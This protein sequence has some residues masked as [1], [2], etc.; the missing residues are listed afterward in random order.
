MTDFYT[1]L[2]CK[3]NGGPFYVG[4]GH[5]RRS[6]ML[7]QRS[8]YH[9]RMIKK[10]GVEIFVFPCE[11]EEQAFADEIQQIAQLRAEGYKL[12][13]RTD[14]GDG[15]SGY[16]HTDEAKDKVSKARK[17]KPSAYK[18]R[19]QSEESK[20]RSAKAAKEQS[21]RLSPEQRSARAS[22]ASKA[23]WDKVPKEDRVMSEKA[24]A[25]LLAANKGKPAWNKGVSPSDETRAKMCEAAKKKVMTAEH[26]AKIVVAQRTP[27]MRARQ[28][29]AKMGRTPWNKGIKK[30]TAP[31]QK[32]MV[33]ECTESSCNHLIKEK[34][35]G[36]S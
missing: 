20:A 16:R 32:K 35:H 30:V 14:G 27:E 26:K 34:Y 6:H 8:Q 21:A 36:C 9:K 33:S 7:T 22:D 5:G 17:G 29:A 18:G 3:P 28:S 23:H 25:S 12:V 1:Y 2:H 31:G 11:S 15:T 19:T 10:Y 24:R 4:K 13:N